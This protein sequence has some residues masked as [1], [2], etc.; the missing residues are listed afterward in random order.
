MRLKIR[1]RIREKAEKRRQSAAEREQ[2]IQIVNFKQLL[3]EDICRFK[4]CILGSYPAEPEKSDIS[5]E[6]FDQFSNIR[7]R[8][9]D[10]IRHLKKLGV[11]IPE[12]V[13]DIINSGS[14]YDFT[15]HE[16]CDNYFKKLESAYNVLIREKY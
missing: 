13:Q 5:P 15:C 10:D 8:I 6:R 4:L 3:Y 9:H 12:R 16:D 2:L 1:N 14:L 11:F 7:A